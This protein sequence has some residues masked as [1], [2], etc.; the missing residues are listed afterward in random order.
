MNRTVIGLSGL[1]LAA[2]L[3]AGGPAAAVTAAEPGARLYVATDGNDAWSGT[4]SRPNW[5][6]SDGPFAT[7]ERA[8]DAVRKLKQAGA[9]PPGGVVVELRRGRYTLDKALELKAEDSGTETAPVVYRAEPGEEVRLLAGRMVTGWQ[10][11]TDATVLERLPECAR[12][13]VVQ[14]D[15]NGLGVTDYGKMGGGFG[16]GG[17]PGLELFFNDQPTTL[18]RCPNDGFIRIASV[19]GMTP[20][21]VRGTKGC[22]EGIF[23]Y[24]GDL[25]SRWAKEK[26]PWVLGYWFWD[27]AEMREKVASID[28]AKKLITLESPYHGYGYRKNQWFYGFNLLCE[29]DQPGEWYLDRETGVLYLWPPAPI[30]K[31]EA[32][33][34]LLANVVAMDGVTDVEFRGFVLEG[35]RGTAVTMKNSSRNRITGCVIRNVGNW[36]VQVN[37]GK[38]V[39]VYGC[40]IYATGQ[41]GINLDG[42]DRVKLDP[43]GHSAENNHI[44]H[45]SRWN[46]M[47]QTGIML[48][49]VGNRAAHNLLHDSP[50]TAIGFGGNDQVIEYNEIHSVCFESNDAGA[51]YA[52]RNWTMRGNLLRY[53]Y[54]HHINGFEGRGCVGI[55]LDDM[56]SSAD[57]YGNLFYKVTMA[58]F[59]GGG[60]DNTVVNNTFVDCKPAL[61]ID[62]RALGWA[63]YH[64]ETWVK[65]AQ[66]KQ[67]HLGIA[68][69]KPPYSERYPQLLHLFDGNPA[70][71]Q[72]NI[73]ARNVCWGGKWD[74]ID[75][76]AKP[77]Q[78]IQN[79]LLDQDP[80]FVDYEHQNF[81]LRDD[82]PAWALGFQRIPIDK[83]GVYQDARRA[84]WPV[85][86]TVRPMIETPPPKVAVARK[87]QPVVFTVPRTAAPAQIDATIKPEE[88]AGADP[89]KA[90]VIEQ[91]IEGEK[92][93][94]RSL[95]WLAH[96]GTAL[97]IAVDNALDA[98]KTASPGKTWGQDDAVELAFRNPAAGKDAPI[99]VL[100]GYPCGQFESS[101]EAGAPAALVK[102]AAEGVEYK[103]SAATP[104]RW[105]C[106]WRIPMASLGIDPAQHKRLQFNLSVRKV[107]I[108]DPQWLE[109]Q[110]TGACTWEA[111][112]AGVLELG[113]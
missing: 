23:T 1:V 103:A 27:W 107:S 15:L 112:S 42:G 88:W 29:I 73:I 99:L 77:F 22:K 43:A 104:G 63:K 32:M 62:A 13:Q 110:G 16:Q 72:G 44:H 55:Y 7:L 41:G 36:A 49:G 38:N 40:D 34:T 56:F 74:N 106:E 78:T 90:M 50:H 28:V 58:A 35:A 100:R 26:D 52:G 17:S 25:P 85:T 54:L 19:E 46:R 45:W 12:S 67:T 108:A 10:P 84:S 3:A 59:I 21:D 31:S 11:V 94:P 66:E 89:A 57:L 2:M 105:A 47:Y 5:G 91:G 98:D 37:G 75:G 4:R 69:N 87:G 60:R 20:L 79:N 109:W 14:A 80:K 95:A 92:L 6:K 53:N 113:P 101:D 9:L 111:A 86:H 71:P 18:S 48:T 68:Y 83:I 76:K 24:D 81:Q 102:R 70:E 33:V 96:D 64:A 8:R 65:E 93:G 61:H 39:E 97:F 51:I 82:S 30:D